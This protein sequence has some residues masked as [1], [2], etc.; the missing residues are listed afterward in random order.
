ME[1]E[2]EHIPPP[3]AGSRTRQGE[4]RTTIRRIGFFPMLLWGALA[5]ALGVVFLFFIFWAAIAFTAIGLILIGV[6]VIR[7]LISGKQPKG[8]GH[9]VVRFHIDR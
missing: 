1:I 3:H 8:T 4:E 2:P 5:I 6:N 7:S 9:T